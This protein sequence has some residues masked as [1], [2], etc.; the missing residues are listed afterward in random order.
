MAA[1]SSPTT[2]ISLQGRTLTLVRVLW[3][4]IFVMA[5][6]VFVLGLPLRYTQL[7]SDIIS[8]QLPSYGFSSALYARYRLALEVSSVLIF[9]FLG[10][11]IFWRKPNDRLAIFVSTFLITFGLTSLPDYSIAGAYEVYRP[12]GLLLLSRTVTFVARPCLFAFFYL[13]PT[14]RFVPRWTKFLLLAMVLLQIPWVFFPN[15]PFSP[16]NWPPVVF[17]LV[18]FA[19]WASMGFAQVYRYRRTASPTQRQQIKWL[20]LGI[21]LST[22]ILPLY[23]VAQTNPLS[24]SSG[25]GWLIFHGFVSPL[26][27]FSMIFIPLSIA[28]GILHYRL[29]EIDFL[30]NRSLVYG[31][32]TMLLAIL[33]GGSLLVISQA[34]QTFTNQQHAIGALVVAALLFG[35]LFQPARIRLQRFVDRRFYNI[36]I[37]YHPGSPPPLEIEAVGQTRFGAYKNLQR[38]GRGGMAEVFR[39]DHPTLRRPVAIKLLPPQLAGETDFR[40]RFAREAQ[41]IAN[42]KHPNIVQVFDFGELGETSYMVME[43]IN[44]PDLETYLK[45]RG[46]LT[47]AEA[48]PIIQDIAGAL[49]YAH[50]QGLVHR[51]VKASNVILESV[52]V[53][54]GDRPRRIQRAVLADFGIAKIVGRGTRFTQTGGVLGTFDYIAPEQIQAQSEIDG[55][56]DIYAF[57][58]MVYY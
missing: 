15:S 53:T 4:A 29:W 45:E 46:R 49:D 50:A 28:V 12:A 6:F 52:T 30:I 51:D 41:M 23:F 8:L 56:A 55:R 7:R 3:A 11:L 58:V 1:G 43:F 19:F 37:D 35:M 40:R 5:F 57:G 13:F 39:A 20:A 32:L 2:H 17:N 27:A 16:P 21:V 24:T 38:I 18:G 31:A 25:P 34:F 47:L 36:R 22:A 48:R 42:L 33:F 10:L 26:F 9:W 14:G 54:A 44:G